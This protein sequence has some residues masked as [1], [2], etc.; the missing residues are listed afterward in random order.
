VTLY[1]RVSELGGRAR[2]HEDQGFR[3]NMGPHALYAQGQGTEVL[4]EIGIRP[5]G[6]VPPLGGAAARFRGKVYV[7]PSGFVS[8]LTTGLLDAKGKLEMGRVFAALPRLD[9]SRY[10]GAPLRRALA[11]LSSH[12]TVREILAA[13]V[14]LTSYANAIDTLC[15]ASALRQLQASLRGS[16]LYLHGGWGQLV[17]ALRERALAQGVAIET[18]CR[19]DAVRRAGS[20][21]E[22]WQGR[23]TQRFDG[24]VLAVPPG[25]ARKLVEAEAGPARDAITEWSN[26]LT[27]VRA[28]C[29]ELG[30]A[31]LPRPKNGFALGIDEPTYFSVHSAVARELAPAGGALIHC[32][33]YLA[34]KESPD[35]E[36][37]TAQLEAVVDSMQPGWRPLVRSQR[38]L[39]SLVVVNALPSAEMGGEAG[40]PG[41]AVPGCPGLFVA[42]DWVGPTAQLADAAFASGRA[43]GRAVAAA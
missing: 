27:P 16:V 14:R 3:F 5:E 11:E 42:G 13:I 29:L 20:G 34:P 17:D 6:A 2:T 15:A 8:L 30:L 36:E 18:A 19:V 33:R 38:L 39:T 22:L 10:A 24:V 31:S 12:A 9:P 41:P 26:A 28:A 25:E 32:A 35:R 43:A 23:E 21:L 4:S 1:E 37:L 40:R 7:L